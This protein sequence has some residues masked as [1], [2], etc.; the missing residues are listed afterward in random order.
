MTPPEWATH[1]SYDPDFLE[2]FL[3]AYRMSEYSEALLRR[4]YGEHITAECRRGLTPE[5]TRKEWETR[6]E[7]LRAYAD[8]YSD[9]D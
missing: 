3:S 1:D 8:T 5:E 9:S 6:T 4:K 2:R 7:K